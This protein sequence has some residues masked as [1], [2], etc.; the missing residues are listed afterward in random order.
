MSRATAYERLRSLELKLGT[1][2]ADAE[3]RTGLHLALIAYGLG[4][5]AVR[6]SAE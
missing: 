6:H 3:E 1:D 5:R 2:L 4:R